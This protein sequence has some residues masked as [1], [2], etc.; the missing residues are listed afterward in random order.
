M[1]LALAA[2][3]AACAPPAAPPAGQATATPAPKRGLVGYPAF[4]PPSTLHQV[5]DATLVGTVDQP[6]LTSQG[7]AVQVVTQDWTALAVVS[8]PDVPG[9][10]LP[11]QA[12]ATTCTWT[13]KLTSA[14]GRVPIVVSDFDTIDHKGNVYHPDLLPEQP[15]PPGV[16]EPGQTATFALRAGEP[17]GEGVM[18]WAPIGGH[19]VAKWDFVVEND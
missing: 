19:I 9:E 5:S 13:V 16:L 6:A 12:P 18:R 15:A 1:W 10:G 8:G 11:H 17:V 14:T 4:L 2:L 7:D 3:L